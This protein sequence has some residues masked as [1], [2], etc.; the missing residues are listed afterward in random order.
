[1]DAIAPPQKESARPLARVEHGDHA[2]P[3][4]D[5]QAPESDFLTGTLA[6]IAQRKERD[7]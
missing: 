2:T 6:A 4:G 7:R 1:M 3:R 5:I